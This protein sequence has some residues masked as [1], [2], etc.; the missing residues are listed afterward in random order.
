[1]KMLL[2]E[3]T[4]CGDGKMGPRGLTFAQATD[5]AARQ[6]ERDQARGLLLEGNVRALRALGGTPPELAKGPEDAL[7]AWGVRMPAPAEQAPAAPTAPSATAAVG[8]KAALTRGGERGGG[9]TV[10]VRLKGLKGKVAGVRG[11][12]VDARGNLV[13]SARV[14]Y[15]VGGYL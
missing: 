1:G 9:F 4:G 11:I 15:N 5:L 12:I 10:R 14:G 3:T 6:F 8:K 2:V 13:R 7:R